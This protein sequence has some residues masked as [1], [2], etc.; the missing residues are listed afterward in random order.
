MQ[1]SFPLPHKPIAQGEHILVVDD[2]PAMANLIAGY[3]REAGYT[4]EIVHSAEEAWE[5]LLQKLPI[6]II[7]DDFLPGIDGYKLC[8]FISKLSYQ[9]SYWLDR[10]IISD[11]QPIND[12]RIYGRWPLFT[13]FLIKPFNPKELLAFVRRIVATERYW[14]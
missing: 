8:S 11:Q 14:I 1:E 2:T 7:V 5:S 6:L 4:V 3:L 13:Y 10:I 9:T 12:L